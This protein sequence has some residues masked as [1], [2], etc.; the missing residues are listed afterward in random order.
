MS[1]ASQAS[2]ANPPQTG[3]NSNAQSAAGV[4]T[5]TTSTADR[6][7]DF[8]AVTTGDST[9]GESLLVAAYIV[10][11]MIVFV[12]L[13]RVWRNQESMAKRLTDLDA[14]LERASK[15]RAN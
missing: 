13:F 9:S 4:T 11:W 6:A 14:T 8:Q 1:Q 7:T 5:A 15:K 2:Q 10:L 12:W 3:G